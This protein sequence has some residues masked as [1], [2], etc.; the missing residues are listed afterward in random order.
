M[1]GGTFEAPEN[2]TSSP[3][4]GRAGTPTV[5][6]DGTVVVPV[7][8]SEY[9]SVNQ[10]GMGEW[11]HG[12]ESH[13]SLVFLRPDHSTDVQTI[14][15]G[16]RSPWR[17]ELQ[18]FKAIPNGHGGLL[19]GY[20][21]ID[22]FYSP[23]YFLGHV[24]GIDETGTQ[25][26]G[27][28]LAGW[29]QD[30][31]LGSQDTAMAVTW[32]LDSATKRVITP[33]TFE[34]YAGG[35]TNFLP[36]EMAVT[37]VM[38]VKDGGYVFSYADGTIGGPDDAYQQM[39]G[40]HALYTGAGNWVVSMNRGLDAQTGPTPEA[41]SEFHLSG[42]K[43]QGA[44][45]ATNTVS[46]YVDD[47][48]EFDRS[49]TA[50]ILASDRLCGPRRSVHRQS[51]GGRGHDRAAARPRERGGLPLPGRRTQPAGRRHTAVRTVPEPRRVLSLRPAVRVRLRK[52]GLRVTRRW[53]TWHYLRPSVQ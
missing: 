2:C 49:T 51:G 21:T 48:C 50:G 43:A 41:G 39:H 40:A 47:A 42:G 52:R 45:A 11:V 20:N 25:T 35:S 28:G 32:G 5:L 37:S 19:V 33:L 34:G 38:A 27:L 15:L 31:V 6:G 1:Y 3:I 44:N 9:V 17:V 4:P 7:D 18:P 23:S 13:L 53:S 22:R 29:M 46:V 12:S 30:L 36:E 24:I 8:T 10:W 26:G 16:G 14:P